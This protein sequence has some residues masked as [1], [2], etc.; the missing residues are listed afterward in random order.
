MFANLFATYYLLSQV[1]LMVLARILLAGRDQA[2]Q[3]GLTL[4][5]TPPWVVMFRTMFIGS[6][7]KMS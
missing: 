4:S 2:V 3:T 5:T 1:A 6:V 7:N